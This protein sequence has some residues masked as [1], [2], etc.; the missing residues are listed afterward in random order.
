[1]ERSTCSKFG[2]R[3]SDMCR[4]DETKCGMEGKYFQ[5]EPNIKYKMI[6]YY[7]I[8]N[9]PIIIFCGSLTIYFITLPI[10]INKLL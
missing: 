5:N 6:K 2:G 8:N 1:M 4:Y 10:Y 7:I 9:F 3:Y